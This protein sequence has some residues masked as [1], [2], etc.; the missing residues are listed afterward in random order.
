MSALILGGASCVW[1][2]VHTLE[3][4]MGR[5]WSGIVIAANDVGC[6]WPR[7]LDHWVTLHPEKMPGWKELR[8]KNGMPGGYLTWGSRIRIMDRRLKPWGGGSSG[9]LAVALAYQLGCAKVVLCGTP[10]DS[11]PHF[12]ESHIHPEG[13]KWHS[14]DN[15]WRAWIRNM[16]RIRAR[17]RSMSGR[18]RD[19]LGAPTLHWLEGHD[20]TGN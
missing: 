3:D 5:R 1:H 17:T 11:R 16:D 12:R 10:M 7:H 6:H 14:A 19:H 2:D 9:L 18:T 4:L 20:G 13:Q 15:H 8:E